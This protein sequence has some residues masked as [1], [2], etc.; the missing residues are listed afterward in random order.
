MLLYP[1]HIESKLGFDKIKALVADRCHSQLGKSLVDQLVMHTD[2][3]AIE[4]LLSLTE[5]QKQQILSG[6]SFPELRVVGLGSELDKSRV[7]GY[8][9]SAESLFGL[10]LN[11]DI[12][13]TCLSYFK[14]HQEEYPVWFQEVGRVE[15]PMD[16]L[17]RLHR[18]FERNGD[19][20]DN[21]SPQLKTIRN[22]IKHKQSKARKEL[23][24]ILKRA[25]EKGYSALTIKDGRLVVPLSAEYKR[26]VEG[27][28]VDES[29]T[30]K[31]VFLEPLQ[32]FQQNNE[33]R[34]LHFAENREIITILSIMTAQVADHSGLLAALESLLAQLDFTR[35]K[36]K[37]AILLNACK[38]HI[39][40][41]YHFNLVDAIHPVLFLTNKKLNLPV[42]PLNL[43]IDENQRILVISGP[44]AGGKSVC[45][46]TAGLLQMMLQSGMLVPVGID[47]TMCC[48][49]ELFVDIGDEQSIES[50]L[51]TYS[52]H[53]QNMKYF[54]AH[55]SQS[56][57]FLIDEFGT[58]TEPQF[59]GAIAESILM[60]LVSRKSVGLITTH[61]GNLKEYAE[62]ADGVTNGAMRFDLDLLQPLYILDIGRPGSSFALE[63]AANIGLPTE[64]LEEAKTKIGHDPIAFESLVSELE[65]EKQRYN[66]MNKENQQLKQSLAEERDS[67]QKRAEELKSRQREIINQAKHSA[68]QL[69]A[70]ANQKIEN[71]IRSIKESNANKT[72][73][74]KA[75]KELNEFRERNKPKKTVSKAVDSV[76][77]GPI[78]PGDMVRL[79]DSKAQGEVLAI[80]GNFAEILIGA[81][82]SKIK[83][84]R[85]QKIGKAK[86]SVT[87]TRTNFKVYGSRADFSS[88]LD[89]RGHRANEAL[90]KVVE[91]ID[92][93][94][95]SNMNE[96]Q[97]LHGKGNGILR[98][99]IRTHLASDPNVTSIKDEHVE[100]GGAGITLVTLK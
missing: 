12:A 31:T 28:V 10:M 37:T 100:R 47:S 36:A 51:S 67:Y 69:L 76:V 71:T 43:S 3:S 42:Q 98:E 26:R 78:S 58:G 72:A 63:I 35:A 45:L 44:N 88:Q 11:L 23:H 29:T 83:L 49:S 97:I 16:L 34:E 48:F 20:K 13:K 21:A 32:V 65:T 56:S 90:A 74:Q 52:S 55:C 95:L 85:L 59:G 38:P 25:I 54:L 64:V 50:D 5:E 93:G 87:T 91:F 99:V 6:D 75:R 92:Q 86:A 2:V 33:I 19:I 15:V 39:H 60:G 89:V 14:N 8:Y 70:H 9:W 80:S 57:L 79:I 17:K 73:T 30:G 22:Q 81:L 82:K 61:Y 66:Q 1:E 62:T 24:T 96:L 68:E 41:G 7:D 94:I 4:G 53:L 40:Q 46:K 27:L 18:I 84:S 77:P